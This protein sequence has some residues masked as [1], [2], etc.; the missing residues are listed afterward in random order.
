MRYLFRYLWLGIFL[1]AENQVF[2]NIHMFVLNKKEVL[3]P[4]SVYTLFIRVENEGKSVD[5]TEL[6]IMTP[7]K[8]TIIT[9]S[10]PESLGKDA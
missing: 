1:L 9:K 3:S 10:F 8:W 4:G 2:A 7:A 5:F 6:E